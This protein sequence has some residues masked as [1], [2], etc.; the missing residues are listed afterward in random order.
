MSDAGSNTSGSGQGKQGFV[1]YFFKKRYPS[2]IY[3]VAIITY[4][5]VVF[6]WIRFKYLNGM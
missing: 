1:Y 3:M 6:L 4:A 2:W 5:V